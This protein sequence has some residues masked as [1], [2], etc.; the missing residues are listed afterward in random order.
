MQYD[1][2]YNAVEFDPMN[3]IHADLFDEQAKRPHVV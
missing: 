2:F 1:I 3:E